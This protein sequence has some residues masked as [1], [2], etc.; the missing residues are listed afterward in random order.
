MVN[1]IEKDSNY[2]KIEKRKFL[3]VHGDVA[4][5]V[6][7]NKTALLERKI[8]YIMVNDRNDLCNISGPID[9]GKNVL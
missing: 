9:A 2:N 1:K 5:L 6:Y 3:E 4:E 7:G 8:Q